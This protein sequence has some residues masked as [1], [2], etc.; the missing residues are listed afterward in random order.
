MEEQKTS[1]TSRNKRERNYHCFRGTNKQLLMKQTT[2]EHE[3]KIN[4]V[5]IYYVLLAIHIHTHTH[6]KI[7]KV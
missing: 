5:I 6:T 1:A 2:K 3:T 4:C 7:L